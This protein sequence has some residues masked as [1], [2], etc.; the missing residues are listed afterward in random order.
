MEHYVVYL[1]PKYWSLSRIISSGRYGTLFSVFY[2][3]NTDLY[4]ESYLLE[5]MGHYLVYFTSKILFF[6]LNHISWK[7]GTL[8]SEFYLQNTD[9]Y[10]ESYLLEYIGHYVVYLP[11]KYWSLSWIISPG[12]YGTLCSV[13]TSKIL[14]FILNNISWKIGT[15]CSQFTSK[16]LIFILNH[17]SWK[18]WNTMTWILLPKR[19]VLKKFLWS[20][21]PVFITYI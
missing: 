18:I 2:L 21:I 5:D 12:R 10:P 15:L 13:F 16:I 7:L 20:T 3:Q 19:E 1:P 4:P 9:L 17:I 11:P 8:F 14:I 6:I